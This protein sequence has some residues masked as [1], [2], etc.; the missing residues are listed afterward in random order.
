VGHGESLRCDPSQVKIGLTLARLCGLFQQPLRKS[1]ATSD[2]DS[3]RFPGK[4]AQLIDGVPIPKNLASNLGPQIDP[5]DI[6]T[7]EMQRGSYAADYGDRTYGIFNVAPRTGFE[8]NNEASFRFSV[9][10]T[11]ERSS[12]GMRTDR[13]CEA[14][15]TRLHYAAKHHFKGDGV[16]HNRSGRHDRN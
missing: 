4:R 15:A 2:E 8:H 16:R 10:F 3:V 14:K 13:Y 1:L 9:T 11:P 6:D 12:C 7:V 5:K